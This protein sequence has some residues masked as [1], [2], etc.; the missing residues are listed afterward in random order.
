MNTGSDGSD[1]IDLC[2]GESCRW[3]RGRTRQGGGKGGRGGPSCAGKSAGMGR[4]QRVYIFCCRLRIECPKETVGFDDSPEET[5]IGIL[6][7]RIDIKMKGLTICGFT[8]YDVSVSTKELVY[9]V[10][11]PPPVRFE[12]FG[13]NRR[14]GG[15]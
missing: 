12:P 6:R 15:R 11:D 9:S 2:S 1:R 5:A 4:A 3:K 13:L 10:K 14:F 7:T 8:R